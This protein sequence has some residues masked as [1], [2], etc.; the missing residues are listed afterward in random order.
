LSA[1]PPAWSD[2]AFSFLDYRSPRPWARSI[3]QA[4]LARTMPPW[5]A[6]PGLVHFENG[7]SL[8]QEEIDTLVAWVDAGTPPAIRGMHRRQKFGVPTLWGRRC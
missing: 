5:Y 2:W 6:D 3:K 1:M 7:R 4:V 8:K